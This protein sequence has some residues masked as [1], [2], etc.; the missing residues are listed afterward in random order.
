MSENSPVYKSMRELDKNK[1]LGSLEKSAK[2]LKMYKVRFAS[3][4]EGVHLV[5]YSG[6][7]G[8]V[9]FWPGTGRWLARVEAKRGYGIFSLLKY[10]GVTS[11]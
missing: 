11:I 1:K 3:N 8:C 10:I 9:D 4:L 7:M 5:V 6:S 2:L